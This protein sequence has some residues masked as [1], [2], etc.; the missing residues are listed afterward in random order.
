MT[1]FAATKVLVKW[2]NRTNRTAAKSSLEVATSDPKNLD[3]ETRCHMTA[4]ARR[5]M[6]SRIL[7]LSNRL[8]ERGR[9]DY[10]RLLLDATMAGTPESLAH[11]LNSYSRLNRTELTTRNGISSTKKVPHNAAETLA[12]GEFNRFYIRGICI[13][14]IK[15]GS[16]MVRVYRAK[17]VTSPRSDSEEQLGTK[18]DAL[19]LL[20][21]L[22][23]NV[24]VDTSLG[25]PPGPNRASASS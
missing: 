2:N 22:R 7:Y 13:R 15:D 16:A 5:D 6:S 12:E 10:P 21:D 24:G 4:E 1:R 9:Q 18:V 14:A 3:E 8:S 11:E 20:N 25:L 23:N 17:Q 19:A